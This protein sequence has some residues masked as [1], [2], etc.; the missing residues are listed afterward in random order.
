M[1]KRRCQLAD[2]YLMPDLFASLPASLDAEVFDELLCARHVRIERIISR[3]HTSPATGWHDQTEHEWVL[4]LKGAA[5]L[6]FET[7]EELV[8]RK[9]DYMNIPAHARHR[10]SWTAPDRPTIWLAVFYQ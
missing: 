5:R 1:I 4:V 3:G 10:V 8:L 7:G 2:E 6:Q 9:G